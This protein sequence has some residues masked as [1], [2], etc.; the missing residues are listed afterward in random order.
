MK[1]LLA[2]ILAVLM[3]AALFVACNDGASSDDKDNDNS[4][5]Q[6]ASGTNSGEGNNGGDTAAAT[7]F[8]SAEIKYDGAKISF[9]YDSETNSLEFKYI[10]EAPAE[11]LEQLNLTGTLAE[12]RSIVYNVTASKDGDYTVLKGTPAKVKVG[13]EGTA[14]EGYIKAAEEKGADAELI[15]QLKG[16]T[17]TDKA[18]IESTTYMIDE[19]ITL[20]ATIS[21]N[22]FSVVEFVDE[23]TQFGSQQS[24][25][26]VCKIENDKF[27]TEENYVNG[28]LE[29]S[30][31]FDDNGDRIQEPSK[32]TVSGVV[33]EK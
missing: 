20:K 24:C 30:Y 7:T 28:E 23:Y 22:K 10:S 21:G 16:Q 13:I 14:A 33:D 3:V 15:A 25:K 9:I 26:D 31:K 11:V 27:S 8:K 19:T 2:I 17:I 6:A 29:E 32:E 4:S 18:E 5:S 12:V 1:K